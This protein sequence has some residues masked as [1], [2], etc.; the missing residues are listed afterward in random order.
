MK[1][2]P[3]VSRISFQNFSSRFLFNRTT[4][5]IYY[6]KFPRFLKQ[7]KSCL[8]FYSHGH[9]ATISPNQQSWLF[10]AYQCQRSMLMATSILS[11]CLPFCTS[12]TSTGSTPDNESLFLVT[13]SIT[14]NSFP[15]KQSLHHH[16]SFICSL[17]KEKNNTFSLSTTK[18]NK[19]NKTLQQE[20]Y[21]RFS[22]M[23]QFSSRAS[24]RSCLSF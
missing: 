4:I 19:Q 16:H 8:L 17:I 7:M 14:L 24:A 21:C 18:K 3:S 23:N 22:Y 2:K 11:G 20:Q 13:S 10:P 1:R 12:T 15:A 9:E 5:Y 6:W